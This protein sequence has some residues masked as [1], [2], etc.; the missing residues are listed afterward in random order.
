VN[1]LYNSDSFTAL[2]QSFDSANVGSRTLTVS[3]RIGPNYTVTST[4]SAK[5]TIN[6]AKP[7]CL[8]AGTNYAKNPPVI[9]VRFS[10][11]LSRSA[12]LNTS[13]YVLKTTKGQRIALKTA[14]YNPTALTVTLFPRSKLPAG[15]PLKLTFN[16][17]LGLSGPQTVLIRS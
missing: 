3:D 14:S 6:Q 12:A 7:A 10:A 17:A 15:R 2:Y 16:H 13:D 8:F 1:T 4:T 9:V 5:G 11:P